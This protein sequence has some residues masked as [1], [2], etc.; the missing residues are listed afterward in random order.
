VNGLIDLIGVDRVVFGADYPHPEGLVQSRHFADPLGHLSESDR[1]GRQGPIALNPRAWRQ[2]T[3]TRANSR[4]HV[5]SANGSAWHGYARYENIISTV[6]RAFFE[7]QSEAFS[8]IYSKM[9]TRL[10]K[11]YRYGGVVCRATVSDPSSW[12]Q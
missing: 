5:E 8:A 9:I 11:G 6:C 1:Q 7:C 4:S 3:S 10:F 12:S 2:Q